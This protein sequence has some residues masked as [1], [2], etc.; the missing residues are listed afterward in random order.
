MRVQ[1][2]KNDVISWFSML[3]D[4]KNIVFFNDICFA[5]AAYEKKNKNIFPN[6]PK[7]VVFGFPNPGK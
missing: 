2:A 3:F 5:L 4:S 6:H 7:I 1:I